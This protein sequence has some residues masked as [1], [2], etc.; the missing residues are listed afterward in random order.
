MVRA[1]FAVLSLSMLVGCG[2]SEPGA[3]PG[4]DAPETTPSAAST[5]S[6]AP[7][8]APCSTDQ[9]CVGEWSPSM[10]GCGSH[11]RCVEGTCA[12]P[13]AI[14][15]EANSQTARI[16]FEGAREDAFQIELADAPFE[17]TR[18][19]MCRRSMK[20]DWGMLFFMRQTRAQRFWMFNTLIA[21]DMVFLDEDWT[22]V[23]VV[24]ET[25]P[26]DTQGRGVDTPSRYVLE[27]GAGVAAKHDIVAGRK[28]R[29]Y[30]PQ[31]DQ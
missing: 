12:T 3:D 26:L 21:L 6:E 7:S 4:T 28:A 18:G 27:L 25:V 14:T 11:D 24:A 5:P 17:T 13:P 19:L 22:V 2:S 1:V 29:Y 8:A 10:R 31:G 16:V 30:T 15:G 20:P 23:G 9:D